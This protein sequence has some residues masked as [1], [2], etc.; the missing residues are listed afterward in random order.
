MTEN[1]QL[2]AFITGPN[3]KNM[4]DLG[5]LGGSESGA[6][7]INDAGQVVGYSH[8]DNGQ[9]HAFITGPDGAG[10]TDLGTLGGDNS[11][12]LG[13]NDSGQVV[14]TSQTANGQD[15]AFITGP[16]GAGM[17][18]LASVVDLPTD[19]TYFRANAVNNHGQLIVVAVV[20]EPETYA[21]LL[22]G[23]GLIGFLGR[24]R[25]AA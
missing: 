24:G 18:D 2:H 10:M 3:D 23:L 16:D 17:T 9:Y 19:F 13:I 8:T 11:H 1:R 21:M 20:P 14:G 6:T 22:L 25:A 7:G 4:I 5:T 12:A 15:H